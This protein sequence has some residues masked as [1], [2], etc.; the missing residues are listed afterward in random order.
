MQGGSAFSFSLD[1][2]NTRLLPGSLGMS[3]W[4]MNGNSGSFLPRNAIKTGK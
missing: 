3:S 4:A 2:S 1:D